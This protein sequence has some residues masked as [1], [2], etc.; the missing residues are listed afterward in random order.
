MFAYVPLALLAKRRP[1]CIALLVLPCWMVATAQ[2]SWN[3]SRGAGPVL[4]TSAQIVMVQAVLPLLK[5]H[6]PVYS[7]D[8]AFDKVANQTVGIGGYDKIYDLQTTLFKTYGLTAP[9]IAKQATQRYFKTWMR[10]PGAMLI[11]TLQDFSYQYL[12]MPFQPTDTIST[13]MVYSNW[14]RPTFYRLNILW[15][16]LM[17]GDFG[18]LPWMFNDVIMRL[19]G[20]IIAVYGLISPWF[21]SKNKIPSWDLR[22]LWCVPVGLTGLYMPVHLEPRYLIPAVPIICVLAAVAFARRQSAAE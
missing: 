16:N 12:A 7:T 13:L 15:R 19:F 9:E 18:A 22:A 17:H 1:L 6:L 10:F 3:M 14:T 20:T 21:L 5:D 11:T 2:I 4:T 8:D